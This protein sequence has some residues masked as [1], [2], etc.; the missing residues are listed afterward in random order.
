M[1]KKSE[2]NSRTIFDRQSFLL[3]QIEKIFNLEE[4][5]T[6]NEN[7]TLHHTSTSTH[8]LRSDSHENKCHHVYGIPCICDS[9]QC[10]GAAM[11]GLSS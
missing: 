10:F 8:A 9:N 2:W 6:A 1:L 3:G 11:K 7:N 4:G 5:E